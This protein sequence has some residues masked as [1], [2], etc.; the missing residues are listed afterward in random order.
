MFHSSEQP[1]GSSFEETDYFALRQAG[2]GDVPALASLIARYHAPLKVYLSRAFPNVSDY[3]DELL[4]DFAQDRMLRD[5]WL[6][7]V[8]LNRGRF[9][10][11]LKMSLRNY[12][13]NWLR[14][15][16]R[17]RRFPS[18]NGQSEEAL[19][20]L[21]LEMSA[22]HSPADEAYDL[23]WLRTITSEIL[24][25]MEAYCREPGAHQPSRRQTWEVFKLRELAPAFEGAKPPPY[26]ELVKRVGL[27]DAAEGSNLLLSAKR[28]FQ[29]H[30]S[31]V[32]AEQERGETNVRAEMD[33]L[34]Q[35]LSRMGCRW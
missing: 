26:A 31:E 28:I 6:H 23:E 15:Q 34:K 8:D 12:V 33:E 4:Q 10:D 21:E 35:A 32:V 25:R 17:E 11:F 24:R 16:Q 1:D 19:A 2:A 29:R 14:K 7:Q 30:L 27:K 13:I 20:K 22:H 3:A 18:L 5:G 9:R